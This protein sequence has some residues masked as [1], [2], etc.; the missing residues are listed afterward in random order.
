MPRHFDI[1]KLMPVIFE[2]KKN[3]VEV[4][5]NLNLPNIQTFSPFIRNPDARFDSQHEGESIVLL[6]RAHPV[7]QVKWVLFAVLL[8]FIPVFFNIPILK[9]LSPVQLFFLNFFWY[10]FIF[11]FI[12]ANFLIYLFNIGLVTTH[13]IVDIDYQGLLYKEINATPL[14]KIEDVTVKSSGFINSLFQ[15][16]DVFVQTAGAHQNMEFQAV[17]TPSKVAAVINEIMI[18]TYGRKFN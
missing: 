7:T 16:G 10:S 13:R 17:P 3:R 1:I 11:A 15:F 14:S 8:F 2:S 12:F 4:K 18:Q 9:L 6:V 5:P